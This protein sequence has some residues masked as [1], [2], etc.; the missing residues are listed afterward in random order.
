MSRDID[1]EE[2]LKEFE[3]MLGSMDEDDDEDDF[4]HYFPPSFVN[5]PGVK[6]LE[7]PEEKK[8]KADEPPPI[9]EEAKCKHS[10]KKKVVISANL[11]YWYCPSCKADLGDVK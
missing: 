7:Y 5:Y 3:K 1:E 8:K 4:G 10:K 6:D 2:L 9:P 11:K